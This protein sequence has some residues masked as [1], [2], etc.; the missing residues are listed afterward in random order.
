M[1]GDYTSNGWPDIGFG[2]LS[3]QSDGSSNPRLGLIKK[4]NMDDIEN[5]TSYQLKREEQDLSLYIQ[6][7]EG[8]EVHLFQDMKYRRDRLDA[9]RHELGTRKV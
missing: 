5:M 9:I 8:N 7:A 1:R 6:R 4:E 3:L 2:K